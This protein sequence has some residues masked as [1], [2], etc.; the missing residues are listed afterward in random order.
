MKPQIPCAAIALVLVLASLSA[1]TV[2]KAPAARVDCGTPGPHGVECT[3]RRT[4]GTVGMQACWDLVIDCRNKGQMSASAC[5][6]LPAN[7]DQGTQTLPVA[8]FSNSD[9]CDVPVFGHV[10]R[11]K[12]AVQ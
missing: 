4:A 12:V 10:E 3:V 1:C 11:L 6:T 8:D 9:K 5:H 2:T 7:A